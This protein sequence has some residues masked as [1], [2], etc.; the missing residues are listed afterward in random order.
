MTH[1]S[2]LAIGATALFLLTFAAAFVAGSV[3]RVDRMPAAR[4]VADR[5]AAIGDPHFPS[6]LDTLAAADTLHARCPGDEKAKRKCLMPQLLALRAQF[7]TRFAMG[8]LNRLALTDKDVDFDGHDY[9][10]MIGITTMKAAKGDVQSAFKSCTEI[11]QSGCYHG[12]IQT[13][14]LSVP[15][16]GMAEVNMVCREFTSPSADRW[17]RFQCVH[18]MGHGLTM[19][20]S[21]DLPKALEGCDLLGDEWDRKSCYGGAFMENIIYA[22]D[23]RMAHMVAG[24]EGMAGDARPSKDGSAEMAEMKGMAMGG[25]APGATTFKMVDSTD[26]SYPCSILADRY[27]DDCWSMQPAVMLQLNGGDFG[28]TFK[29]CDAAPVRWRAVC[30]A[31]TGTEISGA[32]QRDH[33]RS[34]ALCAMGQRDYQPSCYFGVV[35]NY[36][37]VTARSEDG[38]AF[39]KEIPGRVNQMECYKAVGEEIAV[40]RN[41]ADGRRPLCDPVTDIGFKQACLYGAQV[42]TERPI[43]LPSIVP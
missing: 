10:H 43:G 21:H 33:R 9:S 23:P 1:R 27:Q 12:V 29:G 35:K 14:L 5:I 13:Y 26:M 40:L 30:Y 31:G 37:D 32:T 24:D 11:L 22:S 6:G 3:L 42:I 36:I 18:G 39:C 16:V 15:H 7:G 19:F 2:K 20:Y 25:H 17:L 28:Q 38:L 34:I 41:T 8:A 4:A